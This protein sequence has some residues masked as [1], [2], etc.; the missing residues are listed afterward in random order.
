[1]Q[2]AVL[3]VLRRVR[4]IYAK[5]VK[6]GKGPLLTPLAKQ[7]AKRRAGAVLFSWNRPEGRV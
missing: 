3:A 4:H 5:A 1:M 6:A 2:I 7:A